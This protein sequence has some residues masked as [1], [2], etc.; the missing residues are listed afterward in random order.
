[1]S[2]VVSRRSLLFGRFLRELEEPAPATPVLPP[3]RAVTLP[4][5]RPPGAI[6]E[7]AF[8]ESCTRCDACIK[9]CPHDAL[10]GASPRLRDAAG[11][12]IIAPSLA[13]CLLC[14]ARPCISACETGALLPQLPSAMGTARIDP[15]TCLAH[16]NS[17]CS[18]CAERC[19]VPGAIVVEFGRPRVDASACVGCGVCQYH[20]PAPENAIAILP[21]FN[22]PPAPEAASS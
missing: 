22:R 14:D 20:C 11:T 2:R 7:S 15:T 8:L 18:T 10:V 13:P 17:F 3:R 12:P 19:P 6:E 16:Q 5:L 4:L 21:N 1:M 9:A